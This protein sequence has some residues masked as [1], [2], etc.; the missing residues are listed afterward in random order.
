[1]VTFTVKGGGDA[2]KPTTTNTR[3]DYGKQQRLSHAYAAPREGKDVAASN[4]GEVD[5]QSRC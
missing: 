5:P 1:M 3:P 4:A 2:R